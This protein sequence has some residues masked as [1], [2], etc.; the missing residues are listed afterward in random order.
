MAEVKKNVVA[1]AATEVK[2]EEVKKEA[3][4]AEVKKEAPKKEAPKKAEVKKA[5]VKKA[6]AKKAPAKKEATKKEAPKKAA[7][8][9]APAKKA[10]VKETF[11]VQFAGKDYASDVIVK[12]VKDAYKATKNKAAIKTLNVYVNTDDSRAYYVINDE[13]H[14]SVEL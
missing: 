10:E 4:K 9:K 6:E 13:F 11:A 1:P 3:P 12:L 14:G 5:E 8:K 7:A 2:K